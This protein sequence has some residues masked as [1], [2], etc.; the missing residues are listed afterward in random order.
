MSTPDDARPLLAYVVNVVTPYR[1]HTLRRLAREI[2]QV[3][4]ATL[5]TH[6]QADQ[7]WERQAAPEIGAV[8]F[9]AGQPVVEQ[10]RPRWMLT[11]WRKGARMIDWLRAHNARAMIIAGYND[12]TRLRLIEWCARRRL[13]AFLTADSNIRG[14][15]ARGA[16]AL[17]KHALVRRVVGRCWGVMPCGSLGA[18]YFRKYGARDERIFFHPYEP[19]YERIASI[20]ADRLAAARERFSLDPARRRLAVSARLVDV[21]R[22]DLAIDAF[23]A[24][25]ADRPQWDLLVVGSGP[26]E[27]ALRARVPE[28]LRSRVIFTGFVA[29]QDVLAAIYRASHV[30]VCPSDYEPWAV[31]VNE[32]VAAGMAVIASDVVGAAAE[33]VR[34]GVNGRL[35]PAGDAGA[36]RAAMLDATDPQRIDAMRE[37]SARVLSDW[38][39]AGDP[40]EGVRRA[41]IAASVM[42]GAPH[43]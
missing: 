29:D 6:D 43:A 11:D 24:I 10:A 32:A 15:L 40:I 34:D 5:V 35:F 2:P 21:K 25:A 39:R 13:P 37:G 16:R 8:Y 3:R 41:L 4:L 42:S 19:D 28:A 14:D 33:L 17:V 31:V 27:A 26:L 7:A 38:R 1:L 9:G 36:L 22:V 20:P 12:P 23:A 30:L 18:A